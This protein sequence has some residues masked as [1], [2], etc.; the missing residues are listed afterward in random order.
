VAKEESPNQVA[1]GDR[2]NQLTKGKRPNQVSKGNS[3][4]LKRISLKA[5]RFFLLTQRFRLKVQS[6]FPAKK[7]L[8]I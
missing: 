5:K 3:N 4:L 2:P 1:K 8:T 6:K 7:R